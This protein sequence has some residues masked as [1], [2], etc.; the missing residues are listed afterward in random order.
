MLQAQ[1]QHGR[2][3]LACI[4]P[5]DAAAAAAGAVVAVAEVCHFVACISYQDSS[6]STMAAIPRHAHPWKLRQQQV[7]QQQRVQQ[8]QQ[9]L[10]RVLWE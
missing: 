5:E 4:S 3:T 2:L 10:R 9:C 6:S 1:Q 7:R 8:E